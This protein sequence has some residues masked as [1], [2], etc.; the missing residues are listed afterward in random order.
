MCL[1][2]QLNVIAALFLLPSVSTIFLI[3][4]YFC[5][6]VI[7]RLTFLI[8]FT[9]FHYCH[10]VLVYITLAFWDIIKS[11]IVGHYHKSIR[12]AVNIC[13]FLLTFNLLGGI[14]IL[15]TN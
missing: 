9:S 7:V 14:I 4:E 8:M 11:G 3:A 2:E 13:S 12:F 15:F 1:T 6:S 5:S 10:E